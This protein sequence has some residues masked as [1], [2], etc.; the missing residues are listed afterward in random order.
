MLLQVIL[1]GTREKPVV[2]EIGFIP[3]D[4]LHLTLLVLVV[5]DQCFLIC[6]YNP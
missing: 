1:T 3:L 6:K 2:Y 4:T 5:T